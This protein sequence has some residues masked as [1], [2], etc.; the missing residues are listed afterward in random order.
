VRPSHAILVSLVLALPAPPAHAQRTIDKSRHLWS[1]VNICD[2]EKSPNTIGLRASMPGSGRR[3]ERMFMRFRVQYKGID[4]LW[5]DFSAK[6]TTSRWRDVGSARYKARQSGFSF[7][8][9]PDPGQRFELRGVVN[10]Q[11]RR[12]GKVVR[13]ATKATTPGHNVTFADPEGYSA[14][15]C[16]IVG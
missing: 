3:R 12:G 8:F 5:K 1:T 13:R 9:E 15:T 7:P 16:E 10:F 2:T 14:A 4:G 6:S 11:W